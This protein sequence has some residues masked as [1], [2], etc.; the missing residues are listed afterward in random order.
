MHGD[1]V[2]NFVWEAGMSSFNDI[3]ANFYQLL[4]GLAVTIKPINAGLFYMLVVIN[5][6]G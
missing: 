5:H 6:Y 3:F 4:E 2:Q 1:R